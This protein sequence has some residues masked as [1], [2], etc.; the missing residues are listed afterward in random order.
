MSPE[1]SIRAPRRA[2]VAIALIL[3]LIGSALGAAAG[4]SMTTPKYTS[5]GLIRIKLHN[6]YTVYNLDKEIPFDVAAFAKSQVNLLQD[7][8]VLDHAMAS[9]EWKRTARGTDPAA[10]DKFR[11]SL[12]VATKPGEPDWIQ[13]KFTDT[14][15]S[16]AQLAVSQVIQSYTAI[17]GSS[18]LSFTPALL[19]ELATKVTTKQTEIASLQT[20]K[21]EIAKLSGTTDLESYYK[22]NFQHYIDLDREC[23]RLQFTI[24]QASA[25]SKIIQPDASDLKLIPA[26]AANL[27]ALKA[28]LALRTAERD[29]TRL[30]NLQMSEQLRLVSDL[31]ERIA[32]TKSQ[33]A[34]IERRY[35]MLTTESGNIEAMNRI[36]II[37]NGEEPSRPSSDD[38]AALAILGGFLG[39]GIGLGVSR[40][41][42]GSRP[43]T[44]HQA[45]PLS[46]GSPQPA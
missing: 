12:C 29:R 30:D 8:R 4:W 25:T 5:T 34:D 13:V 36:Q 20:Q 16:V 38:R 6:R 2:A 35:T 39:A 23:F 44:P 40:L 19:A 45:A 32:K 17:Y 9:P 22:E 1:S 21:T 24:E 3:M 28:L 10:R 41:V 14:D 26:T 7:L 11:D 37:S 33:L 27:E 15:P 31:N 43:R 42:N 18:E 46:P